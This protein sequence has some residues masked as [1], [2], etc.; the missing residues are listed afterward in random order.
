MAVAEISNLVI[1]KGTYFETTFNLFNPDDSATVL[2]GLTTTYATIRKHPDSATSVSF[3]SSVTAGTG[4][5]ELSLTEEQTE[6]LESGRNYFDVVLTL[7]GKKK[8]Y[9]KGTIIVEESMS[10]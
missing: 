9:V 8:K 6:T 10:V 2:T 5:I 4:T 3:A 7:D 1:E